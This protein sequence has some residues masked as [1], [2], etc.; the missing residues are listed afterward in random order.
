[1]K[2]ENLVQITLHDDNM[3]GVKNGMWMG[4]V[5]ELCPQIIIVPYQFP[6]YEE[7][8]MKIFKIFLEFSKKIQVNSCDEALLDL[9]GTQDPYN[10]VL[11]IRQ[12]IFEETGCTASAGIG[13]FILNFQV[14]IR[15]KYTHSSYCMQTGKTEWTKVYHRRRG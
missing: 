12:R 14:N 11:R 4:T 9:T 3:T 13:I 10:I 7:I 1:M 2:Q 6:L 15:T 8:S 5:K